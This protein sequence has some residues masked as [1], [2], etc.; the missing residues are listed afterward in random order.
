V[1]VF[2]NNKTA[3]L[4]SLFTLVFIYSSSE[5]LTLL[6]L[7]ES[8]NIFSKIFIFLFFIYLIEIFI[9]VISKQ[10]LL[11]ICFISTLNFI[12][13]KIIY[14]KGI[15]SLENYQ[16]L[17]LFFILFYIFLFFYK[18]SLKNYVFKKI[19]YVTLIILILTPII[20][21]LANIYSFGNTNLYKHSV[22]GFFT[23]TLSNEGKVLSN[24]YKKIKLNDT[25]DIYIFS[26]DAVPSMQ[27]LK[28]YVNIEN[29][30]YSDTINSNGRI[31]SNS[32]SMAVP[33]KNSVN[34]TLMLDHNNYKLD[35]DRFNGKRDS[36]LFSILRNNNYK[37]IT[38]Y[39]GNYLGKS[40]GKFIDDYM[41]AGNNLSYSSACL[42][43][44]GLFSFFVPRFFGVC[45]FKNISFFRSKDKR[46]LNSHNNQHGDEDR[47]P[48]IVLDKIKELNS[49]NNHHGDVDRL[50]EIVLNK[51]KELN[52]HNNQHED[53]VRLAQIVLDKIKELNSHNNQHGDVDR[54]A[55]IVLNKIIDINSH[56]NQHG[57]MNIWPQIVLDKI[58]ELNRD[59]ENSWLS[60]F[61]IYRPIGHTGGSYVSNDKNQQKFINDDFIPLSKEMNKITKKIVEINKNSKK[62]IIILIISDHGL[63]LSRSLSDKNEYFYQDRHG[64]FL[65][66]L[67]TN[68]SCSS[69]F[70]P[71]YT[72]IDKNNKYQHT[73]KKVE[74]EKKNSFTSNGRL[75]MGLIHCLA[76]T[77]SKK[78][79]SNN[80]DFENKNKF[81]NFIIKN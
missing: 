81:E 28:K 11:L 13:L 56:N 17:I 36:L 34:N 80:I 60:M 35:H 41:T 69:E 65:S 77:D 40:K 73:N 70:E 44:Y 6:A 31:F 30:P 2:K 25:P 79:I 9:L 19:S 39:A 12:S 32:F 29:T 47:L 58:K 66:T 45:F 26:F 72:Y 3:T 74:Y 57:D 48:Q 8:L 61:H 20:L 24:K 21:G 43:K 23:W 4:F 71:Y 67:K 68:H 5:T 27:F 52:S 33:T 15:F 54:L 78:I 50:A 16:Q 7:E 53:G 63:W 62:K 51:I 38:G 64:N 46:D 10:N 75:M 22:K 14:I 55:E 76:N 42:E 59:E 49:H 37:I 1:S 18:T